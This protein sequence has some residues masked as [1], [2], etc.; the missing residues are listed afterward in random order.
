MAQQTQQG[1]D[2]SQYVERLKALKSQ[3][4][5]QYNAA[6]NNYKTNY[7]QFYQ[8][9][10]N[11]MKES[12]KQSTKNKFKDFVSTYKWYLVAIGV[13]IVVIIVLLLMLFS[14]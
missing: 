9:L 2:L 5:E 7:P 10:I 14:R 4:L 1:M 3:S 6:M 13:G 8:Q 11:A 12:G